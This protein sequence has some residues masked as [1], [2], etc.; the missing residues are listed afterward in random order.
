M[1]HDSSKYDFGND[2]IRLTR[3]DVANKAAVEASVE[4]E[5]PS[6]WLLMLMCIL[7]ILA[8]KQMVAPSDIVR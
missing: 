3:W 2:A 8:A 6:D 4:Q 5:T 7:V 1:Y